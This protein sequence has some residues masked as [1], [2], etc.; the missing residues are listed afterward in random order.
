MEPVYRISASFPRSAWER[1][2]N[3]SAVFA[4]S[5]Q[6]GKAVGDHAERGHEVRH[7]LFQPLFGRDISRDVGLPGVRQFF[8]VHQLDHRDPINFAAKQNIVGTTHRP[9]FVGSI[10]QFKRIARFEGSFFHDT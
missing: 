8:Q 7:G 6:S 5:P 9:G 4:R 2:S 10:E 3:R 1:K